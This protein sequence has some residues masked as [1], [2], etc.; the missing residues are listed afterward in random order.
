MPKIKTQLTE[1]KKFIH[2]YENAQTDYEFQEAEKYLCKIHDQ[3][4]TIDIP[5]IRNLIK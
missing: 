3:Y 2:Q 4:G 5:T 1:L